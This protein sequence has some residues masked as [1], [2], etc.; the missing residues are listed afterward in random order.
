MLQLKGETMNALRLLGFTWILLACSSQARV[1]SEVWKK[2]SL[3]STYAS[4]AVALSLHCVDTE[5]PH[6]DEGYGTK[7]GSIR[8][9]HP[10]FFGCYDWHSAVHG[11]WAMLRVLNHFP[12]LPEA[13]AIKEVLNRHLTAANIRA[14]LAFQKADPTFEQPYGWAW[15][16]RLAEEIRGSKLP[17]AKTWAVAMAPLEAE[18]VRLMRTYVR[19]ATQPDRKGLH[20]N[21][22]YALAHSWDYSVSMGRPELKAEIE[23]YARK[24]FLGDRECDLAGE[25][26][27]YDFI[28]PC[29]VEADL[30]RRVLTREEF[31]AWFNRFLPNIPPERLKPVMPPDLNNPYQVH[32]VGLMYQKAGAMLGVAA[33]LA[34]RDIRRANLIRAAREHEETAW[35]AMFQSNYGGTHWLASFAIHYY[36]AVGL[37]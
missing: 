22:A 27:P 20:D 23:A 1:S 33:R 6:H 21:T 30:M 13:V 34:E 31:S 24:T 5:L 15:A 37:E 11:H 35:K 25:P 19:K 17:E 4:R 9:R 16:L 7:P 26:G 12:D 28:S 14:E 32:L 3:D 29:F 10:A 18:L 36:T 2:P 8:Q